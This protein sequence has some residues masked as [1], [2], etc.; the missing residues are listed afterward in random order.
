MIYVKLCKNTV[1][2][3]KIIMELM[4]ITDSEL[5][6]YSQDGYMIIKAGEKYAMSEIKRRSE[7]D[8]KEWEWE[9]F[10]DVVEL[11]DNG[12]IELRTFWTNEVNEIKDCK[13]D[14]TI[15]SKNNTIFVCL[16]TN[17][18]EVQRNSNKR[19]RIGT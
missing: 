9:R 4:R 15:Y 5:K 12:E 13:K 10:C 18:Q 11:H 16:G 2:D 6:I 1:L 8:K 7:N 3:R 14:Y 19:R 17:E